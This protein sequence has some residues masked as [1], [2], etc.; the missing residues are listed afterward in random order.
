MP[1]EFTECP[2]EPE[3]QPASSRGTRPPWK[4]I[5][6]Q[7]LDRPEPLP[8][9]PAE[10]PFRIHIPVWFGALLMAGA[11]LLLLLLSGHL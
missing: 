4:R 11:V 8:A 9:R 5:G 2:P 6:V 3:P 1:H 10:R 7:L